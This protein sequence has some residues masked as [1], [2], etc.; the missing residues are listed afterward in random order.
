MNSW[1]DEAEHLGDLPADGSL[2]QIAESLASALNR[3]EMDGDPERSPIG[4]SAGLD[5]LPPGPWVDL[6]DCSSIATVEKD[7][8]DSVVLTHG[9][10]AW[11][12]QIDWAERFWMAS[13]GRVAPTR[14][15]RPPRSAAAVAAQSEARQPVGANAILPVF[16]PYESWTVHMPENLLKAE[17]GVL[18]RTLRAVATIEGPVVGL[19][20]YRQLARAAGV[21]DLRRDVKSRLN[22]ASAAAVRQGILLED[23]PTKR[24]GQAHKIFR[25]VDQPTIRLRE[26]GD[27][28]LDELPENEVAEAARLIQE[29]HR[30]WPSDRVKAELASRYEL[31]PDRWETQAFLDA[32]VRLLDA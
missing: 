6:I 21:S 32:C 10:E 31:A 27:R 29:G 28:Q 8:L 22:R 16:A 26:R 2:E 7:L 3:G 5:D 20:A 17:Q 11:S 23:N 1:S 9:R 30:D 24:E 18:M 13:P 12:V 4:I 25:L 19:R 14:R 15:R